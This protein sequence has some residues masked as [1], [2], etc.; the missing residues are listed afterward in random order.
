[1]MAELYTFRPLFP[2][3]SEPD[4]LH[5]MCSVLGSPT[6]SPPSIGQSPGQQWSE[7]VRLAAAMKFHFPRCSPTP[8]KQIVPNANSDALNLLAALLHYDPHKRPTA[9]QAL[10]HHYFH[11]G[12]ELTVGLGREQTD[13]QEADEDAMEAA[14]AEDNDADGDVEQPQQWSN[15]S[16]GIDSGQSASRNRQM[17]HPQPTPSPPAAAVPSVPAA[18]SSSEFGSCLLRLNSAEAPRGVFTFQTDGTT[19]AATIHSRYFPQA[20]AQPQQQQQQAQQSYAQQPPLRAQPLGGSSGRLGAAGHPLRA[21][22]TD[23]LSSAAASSSSSSRAV[24][25]SSAALTG[26]IGSS[27]SSSIGVSS[28][29]AARRT[30][31]AGLGASSL[32]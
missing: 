16:S 13:G 23:S 25:T 6:A 10:Q 14:A 3:S 28:L 21:G 9:A 2:G 5:K 26:G 7:G 19:A 12:Q 27:S 15:S 4:T 20:A 30:N 29:S 31:F 8:L 22:M 11:V 1:M 32:R 24:P 17:Q 18:A